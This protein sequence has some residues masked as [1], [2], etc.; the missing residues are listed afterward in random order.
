M[1]ARIIGVVNIVEASDATT[2]ADPRNHAEKLLTSAEG[3]ASFADAAVAGAGIQAAAG[4]HAVVLFFMMAQAAELA[5]K[6]WLV[7]DGVQL[8]EIAGRDYGHDLAK[9]L[10]KARDRGFD[11]GTQLPADQWNRLNEV[12]FSSR[13]QGKP[14]NKQLQYPVADGFV[15]PRRAATRQM[16]TSFIDAAAIKVRGQIDRDR[17]GQSIG[18]GAL[19]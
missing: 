19:Y 8:D 2:F 16:L 17:L 14:V 13:N 15:L 11:P 3:F 1:N 12:Y 9:G 4:A 18:F 7:M 6:A 10:K 5:M